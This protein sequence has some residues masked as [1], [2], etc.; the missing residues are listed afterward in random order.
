MLGMRVAS[1]G[2][3]LGVASLVPA[4]A[5]DNTPLKVKPG[6]WEMTSDSERSGMPPIPP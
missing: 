1:L 5:A 6:L 3:C 4:L 2:L